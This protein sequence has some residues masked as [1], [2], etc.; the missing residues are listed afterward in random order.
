MVER[1]ARQ[2]RLP[3]DARAR[4]VALKLEGHHFE[5]HRIKSSFSA[6]HTAHQVPILNYGLR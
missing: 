4:H 6:P 1:Q 3:G 5:L 2:T